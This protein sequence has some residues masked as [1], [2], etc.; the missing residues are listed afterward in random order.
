MISPAILHLDCYVYKMTSYE[1]LTETRLRLVLNLDVERKAVDCLKLI[2]AS[3]LYQTIHLMSMLSIEGTPFLSKYENL[4]MF[5]C[6]KFIKYRPKELDHYISLFH[7]YNN[8]T[9][10]LVFDFKLVSDLFA[11]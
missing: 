1:W 11:N 3:N 10:S 8:A 5:E 6:S 2:A 4:V 9:T 7:L